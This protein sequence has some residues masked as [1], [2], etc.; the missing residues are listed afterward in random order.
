MAVPV[1]L[2]W[3]N[4]W[5]NNQDANDF[6]HHDGHLNS[7]SY[8]MTS[9]NG[10]IFRVTEHLCGNSLVTGEFP[11]QRPVTQSFDVFFDLLLDKWLSKQSWGLVIWGYHHTHYDVT[12]MMWHKHQW[13]ILSLWNLGCY[14]NFGLHFLSDQFILVL[15]HLLT[16]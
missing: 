9:S 10:N 7:L 14:G 1:L 4:S 15:K 2:A 16:S 8:M 6:R 12:V 13:F 11:S 5:T 3:T